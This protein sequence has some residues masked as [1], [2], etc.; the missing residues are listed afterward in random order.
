MRAQQVP[1]QVEVSEVAAEAALGT[2]FSWWHAQAPLEDAS[3]A[4]PRTQ[5]VPLRALEDASQ[6]A[7]RTQQVPLR[8]LEDASQAAPRTQQV[9]LRALK[10]PLK[11]VEA[12]EDASEATA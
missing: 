2:L 9:P 1:L 7:L 11:A 10:V 4:A 8:A 6:A 12:L 5:Q 3:Q